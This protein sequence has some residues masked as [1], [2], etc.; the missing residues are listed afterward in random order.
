M[1]DIPFRRLFGLPSKSVDDETPVGALILH[2]SLSVLLILATGAQKQ[3]LASYKIL[4]SLYSYTIDAFFGVCIGGGL[5][6]LRLF[7]NRNWSAKSREGSGI[8]PFVSVIAAAIFMVVNA[9]PVVAL[10]VPPSEQ[11]TKS[12]PYYFPWYSTPTVGWS[13]I[14]FGVAYWLVFRYVVPHIGDRKGKQLRVQRTLFFHEEHEYPVQWHERIK[15]E[16]VIGGSADD[17]SEWGR[18]DV[19]VKME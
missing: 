4:V 2:W 17:E 12:V 16:W 19:D 1:P 8:A 10:W 6:Y 18:E 3:P 5:L 11:F 9:F 15:F 7:A 13:V 14:A